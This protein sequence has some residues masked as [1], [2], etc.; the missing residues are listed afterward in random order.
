MRSRNQA[1]PGP[2]LAA[3]RVGSFDPLSES[4]VAQFVEAQAAD[5]RRYVARRYYGVNSTLGP[6]RR[7]AIVAPLKGML[8]ARKKS[9]R[10]QGSTSRRAATSG[11]GRGVKTYTYTIL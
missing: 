7:G 8:M 3:S 10:Q 11:R 6:G 5:P 4:R 2:P 9:T 1:Y